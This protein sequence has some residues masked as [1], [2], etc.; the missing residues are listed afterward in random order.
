VLEQEA[1]LLRYGQA[2]V[3][4]G[5]TAKILRRGLEPQAEAAAAVAGDAQLVLVVGPAGTG[6]TTMVASAVAQ[7]R[8]Q[9]R[10]V[11]G[12]APSGKAAD[13]LAHEAG[14]RAITLASLLV[15]A[16]DERHLPERGTTLIL[17][18]AGMASTED[19][20]RLTKLAWEHQWRLACVGDPFQLPSVA[21]GGM[22]AHWCD[23]LP[24]YRLEAIRRFAEPWEAEASRQLRAGDP[25]AIRAYVTHKRLKALL[26]ALV[27]DR[28]ARR[29]GIATAHGASVAIT[30]ASAAQAR[31][32]NDAI[33]RLA[34]RRG[35]ALRLR[36]GSQVFAGDQIAT[37]QNDHRLLSSRGERV[38]NRQSWTVEEVR[39]DGSLTVVDP[40]RGR[41]VLPT[42]YVA[43]H[44]ELGWAVTA[45]GNQGVTADIG[46]C[47]VEPSMNRAALYVGMTRGREHNEAVVLDDTGK[48]DPAEVLEAVLA[49]PL[50]GETAHAV[51]N[52]LHGIEIIE[53]DPRIEQALELLER[54]RRG[55]SRPR[56]LT[57]G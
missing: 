39:P 22:F 46:M 42:G 44:V 15:R 33:Q 1:R 34:R 50:P 10:P 36:D 55:P 45:Y 3:L 7:L 43:R 4:E 48:A 12:L 56:E 27:A 38:R 54:G 19:L 2:A 28:V 8:A 51:R 20:D 21:R 9:G 29:H 32:I 37:R 30:T 25:R 11:L 41:V 14:C 53:T 23:T 49:R 5:K 57:I 17:D 6:K 13:V 35:P 18:E 24:A 26:S 47:V 40:E 16:D 31:A 52:R